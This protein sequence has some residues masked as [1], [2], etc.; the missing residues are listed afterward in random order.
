[1]R[2][3]ILVPA[4][5][6]ALHIGEILRRIDRVD[7]SRLG[8]E[9]EI[10]VCDDGSPDATGAIV[11]AFVPEQS[12][13]V[14][15]RHARN[16]GKGAAI[17]TAL[18]RA[19]GDIVLVQDADLE[20]DVNDYP[21]LLGPIVSGQADVVFGSRFR[22]RLWPRGMRLPNLVANV[23]LTATANLLFGVRLTDEATCFKVF[24]TEVLRGFD[25]RCEGFEFCPEVVGKLGR[26][27]I[28]VHEVPIEYEAR[29]VASGKKIRWT[30][31]VE[32][33]ATLLRVRISG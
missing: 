33:L 5:R 1:M 25:L 26:A 16:R 6:E 27:R 29:D 31:G 8:L 23:I 7:L 17:R 32:A 28:R 19:T 30:D 14:L 3:S 22:R 9:K 15:V 4:Y 11:E 10:V 18:G 2:L 24:R 12:T 21:A 13:L 20:Y